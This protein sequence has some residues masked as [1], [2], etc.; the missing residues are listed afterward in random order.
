MQGRAWHVQTMLPHVA[1]DMLPH[2]MKETHTRAKSIKSRLTHTHETSEPIYILSESRFPLK[3][4]FKPGKLNPLLT[5][6]R[7]RSH[8]LTTGRPQ[9]RRMHTAKS[10]THTKVKG[11]STLNSERETYRQERERGTLKRE[12][13]LLLTSG[14]VS[15]FI[16]VIYELHININT[17]YIIR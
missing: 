4:I 7:R 5:S 3:S 8:H 17:Q 1:H 11:E 6:R 14:R 13:H 2:V 16:S 12:R 10:H 15:L 9:S